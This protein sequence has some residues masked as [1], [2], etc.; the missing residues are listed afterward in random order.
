MTAMVP[1]HLAEMAQNKYN[2]LLT[3]LLLV[4]LFSSLAQQEGLIRFSVVVISMLLLTIT[5]KRLNP[6]K[7]L[8]YFYCLLVVV[9]LL[10]SGFDQ[11]GSVDLRTSPYIGVDVL[12][13]LIL[14]IPTYFIQRDISFLQSATS[15]VLR[16]VTS[17]LIKGGIAVY[18]LSGIVWATAYDMLYRINSEAFVGVTPETI[19]RSLFYFSFVTLTT[20]G[21]GDV[22]A[23]A[24]FARF[25]ANLEGVFGVMYPTIFIALLVSLYQTH[26]SPRQ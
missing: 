13:L 9:L 1:G 25:L 3:A 18:L 14:G 26:A 5:L 22:S 16:H 15:D 11:F 2:R 12:L 7:P 24:D 8:F 20:V 4:M 17:D 21:Y 19:P 10:L 23:K 6:P